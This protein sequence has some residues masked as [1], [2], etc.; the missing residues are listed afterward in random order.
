MSPD[1]DSPSIRLPQPGEIPEREKED[2]MGAYLMMFASLA[3]GLPIP[4]LNLIASV[5]YFFV[6]RKNGLFVAFHALQALLTHVPVV[7][8]NAGVIGWLIGI[9]VT[10]P[11]DRFSPAFFWYLFFVVLANIAY[12]VW[13]IVALV[14]ARKG[15]FFYMPLIGR[16]C[17][18][19]YYG[20][21]A[22]SRRARR[23][24]ENRPPGGY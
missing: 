18:A 7:L 8:L 13:S 4:L 14:H 20:P 9:L 22:E 10:P 17:F 3:I 12:I 24:W 15:R 6:N 19:R 1:V 23:D 5:I 11:H 21:N 2:A 16:M